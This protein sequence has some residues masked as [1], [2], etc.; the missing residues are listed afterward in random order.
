MTRKQITIK[1]LDSLFKARKADSISEKKIKNIGCGQG[2]ILFIYPSGEA[3]Y[4][5]YVPK[6]TKRYSY[7]R[8][9]AYNKISLENARKNAQKLIKNAKS[10]IKNTG[11]SCNC[12]RFCDYIDNW[13]EEK[14][15][16][17]RTNKRIFNLRAL[18]K[19]LVC[20]DNYRLNEIT[21]KLV[22]EKMS[23]VQTTAG[24]KHNAVS[25]LVQSLRGAV[26]RGYIEY[27][28]LADMLKGS[29]SPFKTPK[30]KGYAWAKAEELNSKFFSKL[31]NTPLI[32]RVLYLYVALTGARLDEAR[33]LHWSWIDIDK[34]IITIPAEYT[35][36][37]R[38][39]RIPITKT[40]LNLIQYWKSLYRDP[41][42]D[43]VFY[44][45]YD[46]QKPIYKNLF[47]CA[48]TS[49][50]NK[51]CTI[52][53]LR[54]SLRT[55]V[56][57]HGVSMVIAEMLI[58]HDKR[59]P[60]VKIYEKKDYLIECCEALTQWQDYLVTQLPDEFLCLLKD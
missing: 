26:Q 29:E 28:P 9:G 17:F 27:N 38:E 42:S 3:T 23:S 12:P 30:S 45:E 1:E 36:A 24:N 25:M 6:D 32:C 46:H 55:W 5:A 51:E 56:A 47:Q 8:L 54:K 13:L 34:G 16:T 52:H 4:F 2:C 48:V 39:H 18:R 22:Y 44:S 43:L 15:T 53:G 35:K 58:S 10:K 33:L 19:H 40:L 59:D 37:M 7:V 11:N 21:A 31:T 41:M 60:L 50:C 57:E 14:K 49:N 20:F